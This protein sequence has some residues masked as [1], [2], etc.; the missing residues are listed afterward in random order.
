ME[1]LLAGF[2]GSYMVEP[3]VSPPLGLRP[4]QD[5]HAVAVQGV[6][7]RSDAMLGIATRSDVGARDPRCST[8]ALAIAQTL[9][10]L[11]AAPMRSAADLQAP[12]RLAC[13]ELWVL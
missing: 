11:D 5:F 10:A 9:S 12:T 7:S 6:V 4:R 8:S 3:L 1:L 13:V 2:D